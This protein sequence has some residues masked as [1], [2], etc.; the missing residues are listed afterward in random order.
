MRQIFWLEIQEKI[1]KLG[2]AFAGKNALVM[3]Q[4]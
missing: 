1:Y 4:Q 2:I 3:E